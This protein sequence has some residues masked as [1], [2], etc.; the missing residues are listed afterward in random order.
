MRIINNCE[1]NVLE[2]RNDFGKSYKLNDL[3]RFSNLRIV[4]IFPGNLWVAGCFFYSGGL[5]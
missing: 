2:N 5:R 4:M 1:L 3:T